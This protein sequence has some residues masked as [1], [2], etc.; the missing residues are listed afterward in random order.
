MTFRI[1]LFGLEKWHNVDKTVAN[2]AEALDRIGITEQVT[3][4]VAG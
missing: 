3:E 1:G 4:E 2:L